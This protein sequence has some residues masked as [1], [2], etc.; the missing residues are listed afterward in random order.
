MVQFPEIISKFNFNLNHAGEF[1]AIADDTPELR[2]WLGKGNMGEATVHTLL[3]TYDL[4]WGKIGKEQEGVG[5]ISLTLVPH[6]LD[7]LE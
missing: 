2:K 7:E 1:S 3:G 4:T 6:I 5:Q